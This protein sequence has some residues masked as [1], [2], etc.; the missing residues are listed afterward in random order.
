MMRERD[1]K[2]AGT[3]LETKVGQ[4]CSGGCDALADDFFPL[5]LLARRG[6]GGLLAVEDRSPH[7]EG[8]LERGRYR[9]VEGEVELGRVD[10]RGEGGSLERDFVLF[11]HA[12]PDVLLRLDAGRVK[13]GSEG[14]QGVGNA[15]GGGNGQ[16]VV[17][18]DLEVLGRVDD[19][20][21]M[22]R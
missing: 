9:E 21:R 17:V 6:G 2:G 4:F 18:L 22:R 8:F 15:K 16:R 20:L 5:A 3:H 11:R 7:A 14:E 13:A 19:V 1:G 10:G 12:V